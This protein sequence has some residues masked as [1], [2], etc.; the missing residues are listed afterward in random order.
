MKR[1]TTVGLLGLSSLISGP[2]M[3]NGLHSPFLPKA[4]YS[5]SLP[6]PGALTLYKNLSKTGVGFIYTND[7]DSDL[8]V[9]RCPLNDTVLQA[10]QTYICWLF[11]NESAKIELKAPYYSHGAFGTYALML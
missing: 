7:A 3:G 10:G 11:T 2:S 8:V 1:I 6:T 9:I 5:W 4:T